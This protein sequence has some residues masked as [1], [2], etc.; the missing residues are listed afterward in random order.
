[1]KFAVL[2][3]CLS[4]GLFSRQFEP[5]LRRE[6]WVETGDRVRIVTVE[7]FPTGSSRAQR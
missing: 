3:A 2:I 7:H 6:A 1:M 4:G 5:E